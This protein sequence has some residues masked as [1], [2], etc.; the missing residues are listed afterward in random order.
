VTTFHQ[1][2]GPGSVGFQGE[3]TFHV[4]VNQ[5]RPGYRIEGFPEAPKRIRPDEPAVQPSRLLLA[6]H[7]LVPFTGRR[8]EIDGLT[9][10]RDGTEEPGPAVRLLHGP[11][12]QGK[13]RLAAHFAGL[14][15]EAGWAVW[16][17]EQEPG[18]PVRVEPP[19]PA[20][21]TGTLVLVDYAERWSVDT[22]HELFQDPLL[23]D[24]SGPIRI[25]LLSRPAGLWWG[26]LAGWLDRRLDVVA[27]ACTLAPLADGPARRT[28]LFEQARDRFAVLLGLSE[29]RARA[30]GPPAALAEGKEYAQV[31][32]VHAAALVAV[33]A[34]LHDD[35]APADP[36]RAS[37]RLLRREIEHWDALSRRAP[38]PMATDPTT[39][40]KAVFLAT[41]TRPV[42]DANGH[43]ALRRA[44]VAGT[45]EVAGRV[46]HDHAYCYPPQ[47]DNTVLEPLYPDRLGE[48]LIGLTVPGHTVATTLGTLPWAEDVLGDLLLDPET[49]TPTPWARDALTVLVETARRWPHVATGQLYPLLTAHPELAREAGG[50]ALIALLDLDGV[51]MDLLE[52]IEPQLPKAPHLDLDVAAAAVVRRTAAHRLATTEDP[53]DRAHIL[54]ALAKR[55]GWA[56]QSEDAVAANR[57]AVALL[58]GLAAAGDPA[59]H[60][61][62]LADALAQLGFSLADLGLREEALEATRDALA[63]HRRLAGADPQAYQA[64]YARSLVNL[65]AQSADVGLLREALAAAEEAV[66][67]YRSVAAADPSQE[68]DLALA[69]TNLGSLRSLLGLRAEALAPT[70]E[71]VALGARL[72][73]ADAQSYGPL[74]AQARGNLGVQL[75]RL[76]RRQEA[77]RETMKAVELRREQAAANPQAYGPGLAMELSNLA[78]NR[79][80][81]GDRA[82]ARLRAREAVEI[83]RRLAGANPRKYEPGLAQALNNLGAAMGDLAMSEESVAIRRRLVDANPQAYR[84]ALAEAL[85]TLGALLA[86][87]GRRT[88]ALAVTEEATA[89]LR[90]LAAD[91]PLAHQADLGTVLAN[92]AKQLI[93]V[94]ASRRR[95]RPQRRRSRCGGHW[96]PAT[97]RPTR[98]VSRKG[99]SISARPGRARGVRRRR[100]QRPRRRSPI[101]GAWPPPTRRPMSRASPRRCPTS[102]VSCWPPPAAVPR[103]GRPA[104]SPWR[105]T[106]VWRR[107]TA[108]TSTRSPRR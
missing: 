24:R 76:G 5:W 54:C 68:D 82:E 37:A 70:E 27:D 63:I 56:K 99:W 3:G 46:L 1:H 16:Q 65:G 31:L 19:G 103:R 41:L 93:G 66:P 48:D 21:P 98:P 10:W 32:T 108:P 23:F 107:P 42:S 105:S 59:A 73:A 101:G 71:A 106:G 15:R 84:S 11:G 51:G 28:A 102:P 74:L 96:R 80:E 81:L 44:R 57:E 94:G 38:Q 13:T 20:A 22:L 83:Y 64:D 25:L 34:C 9:E 4:N 78:G 72:A 53:A 29:D 89:L 40:R 8:A 60:D 35:E 49:G 7:Q 33:D 26:G 97:R 14:S 58:R 91:N 75:A 2:N 36:V 87:A 47:A 104:R 18:D 12:G 30:L 95:W 55:L 86:G 61:P 45:D 62:A 88:E 79:H 50:A 52:A 77:L 43:K 85:L 69:L 100:W 90:E 17:A 6:R 67:V 92:L 39:M